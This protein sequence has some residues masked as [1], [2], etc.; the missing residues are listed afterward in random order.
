MLFVE[1]TESTDPAHRY[2]VRGIYVGS[3][4]VLMEDSL[5]NRTVV[6]P[7]IHPPARETHSA[8]TLRHYRPRT[9]YLGRIAPHVEQPCMV[10]VALYVV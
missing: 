5:D 4:R 10:P 2:R 6:H 9:L 8:G 3:N 1:K 7:I